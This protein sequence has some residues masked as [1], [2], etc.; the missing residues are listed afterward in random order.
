ME[1]VKQAEREEEQVKHC[2]FD[3]LKLATLELKQRVEDV[4]QRMKIRPVRRCGHV[5]AYGGRRT[6]KRQ[7]MM[8]VKAAESLTERK[9]H[10]IRLKKLD[11]QTRR[12]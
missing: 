12:R 9:K 7:R 4:E 5:T 1:G 10:T 6:M 3:L 11:N 2:Q 8:C